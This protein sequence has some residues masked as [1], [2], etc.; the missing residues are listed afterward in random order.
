MLSNFFFR[1][2][3]KYRQEVFLFLAKNKRSSLFGLVVTDG[4]GKSLDEFAASPTSTPTV[5]PT[6]TTS[7]DSGA[8]VIKLF[9]A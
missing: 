7:T 8:G 3:A 2:N 1:T 5:T 9:L 6:P 4:E